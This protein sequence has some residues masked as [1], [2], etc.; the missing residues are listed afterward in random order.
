MQ[1]ETDSS[2]AVCLWITINQKGSEFEDSKACCQVDRRCGLSDPTFLICYTNYS[3]H[4]RKIV[5]YTQD[6]KI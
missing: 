1:V 6:R 5:I 4:V 3:C 2:C